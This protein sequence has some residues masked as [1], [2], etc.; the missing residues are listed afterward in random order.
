[1]GA[2]LP[3]RRKRVRADTREA[4]AALEVEVEGRRADQARAASQ[5]KQV[6]SGSS[7]SSRPLFASS[8]WFSDLGRSRFSLFTI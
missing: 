1:M 6:S 7:S 4:Q 3:E 5:E 2:E 8:S